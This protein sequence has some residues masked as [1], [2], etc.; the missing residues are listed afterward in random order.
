MIEDREVEQPVMKKEVKSITCD[1]CGNKEEYS[2][3]KGIWN[4]YDGD[5]ERTQVNASLI[6]GGRYTKYDF[7][8]CPTCFQQKIVPLF[9]GNGTENRVEKIRNKIK[10][11]CE[12]VRAEQER[13]EE[14]AKD[15]NTLPKQAEHLEHAARCKGKQMA[16]CD[17][18]NIIR[19]FT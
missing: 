9:D 6:I 10:Q 11:T 15:A 14:R 16:L 19:D 2:P 17:V 1:G 8:V 5:H 18:L 7:D 12:I 4:D 3:R 13:A